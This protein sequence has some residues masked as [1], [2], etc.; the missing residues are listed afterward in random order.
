M[1]AQLGL[2][3]AR[4]V[5]LSGIP[6]SRDES[7]RTSGCET[8]PPGP[9]HLVDAIHVHASFDDALPFRNSVRHMASLAVDQR[10]SLTR[11]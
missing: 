3:E 8:F 6:V 11:H 10:S 2:K 7:S 9:L 4:G 1:M 5:V